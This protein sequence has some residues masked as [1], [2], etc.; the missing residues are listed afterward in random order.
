MSNAELHS[1]IHG[2]IVLD[3]FLDLLPD[4]I[5][6]IIGWR[7][8]E[9]DGL[10][11]DGTADWGL[12]MGSSPANVAFLAR[13]GCVLVDNAFGPWI[14]VLRITRGSVYFDGSL[15]LSVI[16]ASSNR[17]CQVG[18]WSSR[19]SAYPEGF[20]SLQCSGRMV[21]TFSSKKDV[22]IL[23]QRRE[24][25][26]HTSHLLDAQ[27]LQ[28]DATAGKEMGSTRIILI[29]LSSR[30]WHLY[31]SYVRLPVDLRGVCRAMS[32]VGARSRRR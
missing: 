5:I 15:L 30:R 28:R 27:T 31:R 32:R 10:C 13:L 1:G 16:D 4:G 29:T 12:F 20:H 11:R 2:G 6:Y 26:A 7:L 22:S 3:I 9:I 17:W 14:C 23:G 18:P 21:A 8:L 24:S 19:F 25:F